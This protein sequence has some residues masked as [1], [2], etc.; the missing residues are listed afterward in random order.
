MVQHFFTWLVGKNIALTYVIL[1]INIYY[2]RDQKYKIQ[3]I[4]NFTAGFA[5]AVQNALESCCKNFD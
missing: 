5:I 4:I 3:L 2:Q 1:K